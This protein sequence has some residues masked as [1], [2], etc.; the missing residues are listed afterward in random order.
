MTGIYKL[1]IQSKS[2]EKKVQFPD[3]QDSKGK[4][5]QKQNNKHKLRGI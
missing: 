3:S 2:R 5:K 1:F 4:I